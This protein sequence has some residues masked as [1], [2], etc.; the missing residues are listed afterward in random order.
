MSESAEY[1]PRWSATVC[2][3]SLQLTVSELR[4]L[5]E[6]VRLYTGTLAY[7]Q[8]TKPKN[9]VGVAGQ[10]WCRAEILR[11]VLLGHTAHFFVNPLPSAFLR[12][13]RPK[14]FGLVRLLTRPWHG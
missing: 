4:K 13:T 9:G 12:P 14:A 2:R 7:M 5:L 11:G 3:G 1:T 10:H 8:R 6:L